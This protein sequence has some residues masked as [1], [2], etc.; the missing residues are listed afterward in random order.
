MLRLEKKQTALKGLKHCWGKAQATPSHLNE[1]N[2]QESTF[3]GQLQQVKISKPG[4]LICNCTC[5]SF[6][7][8]FVGSVM[9]QVT[10]GKKRP[11]LSGCEKA[12]AW[13]GEGQSNPQLLQK[14][15]NHL[16]RG[17]LQAMV[18]VSGEGA[19]QRILFLSS[20]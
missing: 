4:F 1:I 17:N 3:S 18:M 9:L 2:N 14:K 5:G 20:A 7:V 19:A 8:L 11:A 16:S 10:L 12:Q 15:W 13:L 6:V